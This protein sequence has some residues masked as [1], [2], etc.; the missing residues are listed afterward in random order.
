M[1][2]LFDLK[3]SDW[4]KHRNLYSYI[5]GRLILSNKE[6]SDFVWDDINLKSQTPISNN[7]PDW[8]SSKI[9]DTYHKKLLLSDN[10]NE[11]LIGF[12]SV[13]YWG[14]ISGSDSV[15]RPARAL[16]KVRLFRDGLPGKIPTPRTELIASIKNA[17]EKV[18]SKD[19]GGAL[20]TLIN[21][22]FL[23]M[24]FASKIIMFMDPEN[25]AVYD[26]IISLRLKS[27]P[28]LEFLYVKTS[29]ANT[30]QQKIYQMWCDFCAESAKIIN[31]HKETWTDWNG[32]AEAFRAVDVE[33]AFFA[34]GKQNIN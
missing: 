15:I 19:F 24:S 26:S 1:N 12:L 5:P 32:S 31:Q 27:D 8:G 6:E 13:I 23:G 29:G 11:V 4:V 21:V 18:I 25:A 14:Y 16:S 20:N 17:R 22:K 3:S 33:R 30:N 7:L 34:L 2:S 28:N 10:E 9:L